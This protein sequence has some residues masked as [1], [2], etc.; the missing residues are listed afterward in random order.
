[1]SSSA[2]VPIVDLSA[3]LDESAAVCRAACLEHGFFYLTNHGIPPEVIADH[4]DAQRRFFALPLA[5]K[6]TI[7]ADENNRGYTPVAEETLDPANSIVGDGKEGL[8]FGREV[9]AGDADATVPLHGPNQWPAE[10][11]TSAGIQL[12]V[13]ALSRAFWLN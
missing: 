12:I 3:S 6:M 4:A 13:A 8:Y 7:A 11:R 5:Q 9:A 10:V 2:Q 1:M